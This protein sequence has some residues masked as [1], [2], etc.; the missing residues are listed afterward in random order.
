MILTH[1]RRNWRLALAMLP[2]FAGAAGLAT[3]AGCASK[4]PPNRAELSQQAMQQ[5]QLPAHWASA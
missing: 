5:V 4:S 2:L 1:T 3:V